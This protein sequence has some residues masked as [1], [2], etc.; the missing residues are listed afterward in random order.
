M[1]ALRRPGETLFFRHRQR[2]ADLFQV[3][4]IYLEMR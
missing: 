3:H 2:I 1:A 4:G